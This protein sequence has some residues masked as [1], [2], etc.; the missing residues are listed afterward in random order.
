MTNTIIAFSMNALKRKKE[1][2]KIIT[3]KELV[4]ESFLFQKENI[5]KIEIWKKKHRE[6]PDAYL[7]MRSEKIAS[8]LLTYGN[9]HFFVHPVDINEANISSRYRYRD[10]HRCGKI[11]LKNFFL[12][13]LLQLTNCED[14]AGHILKFLITPHDSTELPLMTKLEQELYAS[15]IR[16][17]REELREL[18]MKGVE[19]HSDNCRFCDFYEC[20][21]I[22]QQSYLLA[23]FGNVE[24]EESYEAE[25]AMGDYYEGKYEFLM[26]D[27]Y[28]KT[29]FNLVPGWYS[30]SIS[31]ESGNSLKA[32]LFKMREMILSKYEYLFQTLPEEAI[33]DTHVTF[34]VV[35]DE[36]EFNKTVNDLDPHNIKSL[37][38]FRYLL[39]TDLVF[40]IDRT[41]KKVYDIYSRHVSSSF[42]YSFYACFFLIELNNDG[43]TLRVNPLNFGILKDNINPTST[44]V[45]VTSAH[46]IW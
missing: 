7:L 41:G 45:S 23:N 17:A 8:N 11:D 9:K 40:F 30:Q 34:G 13:I 27:D 15:N 1:K 10:P 32:S 20:V 19:Y 28:T 4:N 2:K 6:N 37:E 44:K 31:V 25:M 33:Y 38:Y 39:S 35:N 18:H 21:N 5:D 12:Q 26:K 16:M 43:R 22:P 42:I 3:Y 29:H 36:E 24:R 46:E 14:T